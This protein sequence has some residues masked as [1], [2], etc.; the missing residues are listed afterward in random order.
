MSWFHTVF[1][2]VGLLI[3]F[4]LVGCGS[5]QSPDQLATATEMNETNQATQVPSSNG[6][7]ASLDLV[8]PDLKTAAVPVVDSDLDP[9]VSLQP[10]TN[11]DS[12]SL[13][14]SLDPLAAEET[15]EESVE[16]ILKQLNSIKLEDGSGINLGDPDKVADL[17]GEGNDLI[18]AGNVD[19]ALG[20]YQEALKYADGND[21]P[22]VR[23]NMGIAYKAKGEAEK[24][25]AEYRKAL[26]LAPE[27]SEAHNNLGNLLKDQKNFD[28]AIYHFEASIKIFPENPSTHN[29]L[30]TVHAM[31]GEVSKAAIHFAKAVRI[32]PTYFDARQNLGV[33]YMQQG[34]L[35]AA[36]RELS[37]AVK[38]A[39]GGMAF[40]Q[41][42]LRAA[43]SRLTA[44]STLQEKQ[45]T[46]SD[47]ASAEKASKIAAGKYQRAMS[48][49]QRVRSKLGK[50]VQP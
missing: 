30:G 39:M 34:R 26:E 1:F 47:I 19:G 43:K 28:E 16:D 18:N 27:Y 2:A 48:F 6:S 5:E 14:T 42:R 10:D 4:F 38:M 46:E 45:S 17:L 33:A 20:K 23:F 24:A 25:I 37:Q 15:E 35:D 36:E 13:E 29:N 49:L 12:L 9:L 41:Q 21:D 32:Q 40:E 44:V 50:P 8:E 31:K 11:S 3:S 22:D 7:E